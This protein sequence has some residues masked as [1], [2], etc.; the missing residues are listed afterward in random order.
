MPD[1]SGKA[2]RRGCLGIGLLWFITAAI[3]PGRA[4]LAASRNPAAEEVVGRMIEA[5]GGYAKW[6]AAPTVRFQDRFRRPGDP[7][8]SVSRVTVELGSRR[9][10]IDLPG[11]GGRMAWDGEKAWS[12][13]WSLPVPPRFFALL[14]YYFLNLPWLTRD[15][16]VNL[17]PPG[18]AAIPG[19]PTA[20][21]T[22]KMTFEPGVGDTPDDYYLLYI[23]PE[24]HRLRACRYIVTYAAVLPE[25]R[26]ATPEHLL[27]FDQL[28]EVD[29]LL[30]PTRYTIYEE[31][32]VVA[33]C[34]IGDWS[35]TDRF[36]AARMVM[37]AGA[38]IDDSAPGA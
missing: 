18:T 26:S 29:G 31:G 9:A 14:N 13:N 1:R 24:T 11:A 2:A 35:F 34:E 25:G 3:P 38:V 21:V 22:V 7:Q 30:V 33:S 27:V 37:P 10:Y 20:Y 32:A 19:D 4:A 17:G 16:G 12:E 6:S 28:A 15:P 5:H 23:H 8:E 36:D